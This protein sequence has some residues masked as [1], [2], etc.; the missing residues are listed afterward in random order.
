[1]KPIQ[2]LPLLLLSISL[3]SCVEK[4]TRVETKEHMVTIAPEF[5]VEE[6]TLKNRIS[7]IIPAEEI[8][9]TSSKT[10][11]T[12]EKD[13]HTLNIKIVPD[14]LPKNG[15]GFYRLTDEIREAVESGISNLEHYQKITIEVGRTEIEN[16]VEHKRSY[17]KELDQ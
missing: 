13:F 4:I 2:L 5:S 6:E 11:K 16:G 14:S 12:G 10:T 8:N 3:T 9:I 1:M 15:I 7:A 17:K